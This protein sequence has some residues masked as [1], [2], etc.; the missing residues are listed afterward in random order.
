MTRSAEIA[1]M[2]IKFTQNKKI[3]IPPSPTKI[4]APKYKANKIAKIP[5]YVL[6]KKSNIISRRLVEENSIAKDIKDKR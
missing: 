4:G 6:G 2:G 1:E 5:I 3:E